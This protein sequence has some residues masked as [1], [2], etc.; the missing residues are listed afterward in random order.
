ML[1]YC[2]Y[3]AESKVTVVRHSAVYIPEKLLQ[4]KMI[5]AGAQ[6]ND[7]SEGRIDRISQS[8]K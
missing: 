8:E 7:R 2:F 6:M 5:E 3:A 4:K 1:L